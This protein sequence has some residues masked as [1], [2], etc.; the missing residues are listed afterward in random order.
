MLS[1]NRLTLRF[2]KR[3]LFEDVNI[4]FTPGNCYGLIGAN[5]AGK[6]TF[7]KILAGEIEPSAGEVLVTPGERIAVLKQDHFE[8]DEHE[9]LKVV[10]MGHA[11][12]YDIMEE[13][14]AL[15]AK[16]DF[17][18]AD[19]IRAS[20]LECEFAELNGWDAETEAARLLNG[21]GIA[22]SL[23]SKKM[24]DLDALEKVKVLLARALF[25]NPDILLLDEPTNHLDLEAINWLEDFLYNFDNTVIVVSHDR[26]F[27]NKVCTHIADIDFGNIRLYVGN[28]DFWFESSQLAM[29]LAKD[30][31]KKKEEK[32]KDLQRFIERF[33][34]NASKA[35]QATSRKKQLEKLTLEDIK[36][37]SR[38][39]PYIDF[40]PDR[41]AGDQL[42][43]VENLSIN[44]NGEQILQDV[45]FTVNKGDKIAFVG[46]DGIAKTTLFKI[47]MGELEADNGTFKWGV[48]TTQAYFP[49]DNTE[50]FNVELNLVDWL[51]QYSRDQ[52][53]SYVRGFLGRMLF[54]GEETQKSAQVLSGGEKVR[55][56]LARTM[57]NGAN[58]LI[59]DE[60]TNHLDL[61]SITALNNGLIK[62]DGTLLF[63]SQDHQFMQTIANRIIEITPTGL[64]DRQMTY[65]EYLEMKQQESR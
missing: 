12:L 24:K 23:H 60:P 42:L 20:E 39:Y 44:I 61:E 13:K 56:M 47:L 30:A 3:A 57:L 32:I 51:R 22:V 14:D 18:E 21:L 10:I 37:S 58:V 38:K 8:F 27:L 36:P 65:D 49:K 6:S 31:N 25:G 26:H 40:K 16:P 2:G 59:L 41:E 52:E 54:S 43:N 29:Q 53:E 15:Y 33:S 64:V 35:K 17:S 4:K 7:L 11:R 62:F 34:S 50:Y 28:Y 45:S 1:T 9:V 55:C 63:V 19:G 5:G 48:S 46:S